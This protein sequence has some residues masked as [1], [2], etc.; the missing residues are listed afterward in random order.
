MVKI[1][2]TKE[3]LEKAKNS[4]DKRCLSCV[5][6]QA[7]SDVL[8]LCSTTYN[9]IYVYGSSE[10]RSKYSN[11]IA[12]YSIPPKVKEIIG[13]FDDNRHEKIEEILPFTFETERLC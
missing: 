6:N 1:T 3:H 12:A 11:H 9:V 13:D 5:V 10:D 4:G 8:G 7:S 2:I